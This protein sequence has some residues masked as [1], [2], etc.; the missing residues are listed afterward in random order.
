VSAPG[1][2]F[3]LRAKSSLKAAQASQIE[4]QAVHIKTL[5]A[6]VAQLRNCSAQ[7][8]VAFSPA[9]ASSHAMAAFQPTAAASATAPAPAA[10]SP[11]AAV[12]PSEPF[13]ELKL[14]AGIGMGG[15][16]TVLLADLHGTRFAVKVFNRFAYKDAKELRHLRAEAGIALELSHPHIVRAMG[17]VLL[18]GSLPGLVLELVRGGTLH[19]LVHTPPKG[20]VLLPG[21]MLRLLHEA[22]LGIEYL[23][24]QGIVHRD[25]KSA[26]VM[27][28]APPR[29]AKICDF[30]IATRFG[31]ES[32]Y[33][34]CVG[35]SRYM[36]PEVV[37]GPYD[38][39]ADIYSFGMLMWEASHKAIPFGECSGLAALFRAQENT[40]PV[41]AEGTCPALAAIIASC[42][43]GE[44][45]QRPTITVVV[46]QLSV[47]C[48]LAAV[49]G[50]Q[51]AGDESI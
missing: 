38:H 7:Q 18:P 8:R 24:R 39:S 51:N 1:Q 41:I 27:L 34:A 36:A 50:E 29:V 40:R 13:A 17:M 3:A 22:G 16:S 33:T 15:Y 9:T 37:F 35:T 14:I 11:I 23:H 4:L 44:P 49:E 47:V 6:E 20:E 32:N 42:W 21:T 30:G 48:K 12:A 19:G 5:Q 2:A 28:T 31:M 46:R 45:T 26:N 25:I 43:L 10:P